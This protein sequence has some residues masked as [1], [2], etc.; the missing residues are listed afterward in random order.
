LP[1][2]FGGKIWFLVVAE[3]SYVFREIQGITLDG[4]YLKRIL[5]A[6]NR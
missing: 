6:L 1:V 3:G 5:I 2:G 4:M